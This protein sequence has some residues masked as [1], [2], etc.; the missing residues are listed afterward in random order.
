M[1]PLALTRLAMPQATQLVKCHKPFRSEGVTK[2]TT[3]SVPPGVT[4]PPS[5]L[6]AVRVSSMWCRA[7]LETTASKPALGSS[8]VM[9]S[10]CSQRIGALANRVCA[11]RRTG[12]SM[13]TAVT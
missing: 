11:R 9:M 7:A 8:A 12:A 2:V 13:S 6:S 3:A 4:S 10:A 1:F 5:R